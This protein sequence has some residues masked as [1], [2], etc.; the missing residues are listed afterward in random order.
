MQRVDDQWM[1]ELGMNRD[2]LDVI[3][4]FRHKA[5][6][7]CRFNLAT[8]AQVGTYVLPVHPVKR[9]VHKSKSTKLRVVRVFVYFQSSYS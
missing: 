7:F 6:E 3:L 1:G 5:Q 4:D 2:R 9:R 8:L